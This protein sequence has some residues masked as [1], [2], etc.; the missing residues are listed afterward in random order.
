MLLSGYNISNNFI[1]IARAGHPERHE[2]SLPGHV[3]RSLASVPSR[4]SGWHARTIYKAWGNRKM[5]YVVLGKIF[6]A[7]VPSLSSWVAKP[8]MFMHLLEFKFTDKYPPCQ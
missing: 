5:R 1:M 3:D 7:R 8:Y 2:G 4:R 6:L